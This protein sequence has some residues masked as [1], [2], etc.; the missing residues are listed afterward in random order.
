MISQPGFFDL[1][2][3]YKKLDERDPLVSLNQ[4][5]DRESFRDTLNKVPKQRNTRDGNARIKDGQR[6]KRFNENCHV[7][8]QK[9]TDARWAKK[10]QE[11]HFGYKNHVA[12]D[13]K[14]KRIRA[15]EVTSA[16][17]HDS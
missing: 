3:R 17:V 13:H 11:T 8:A 1:D 15:Y 12:V 4:L 6:P 14:H 16:E 10:N 2:D 7:G 9:D 5:I